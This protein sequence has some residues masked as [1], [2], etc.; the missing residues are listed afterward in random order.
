M[1]VVHTHE[2]IHNNN[3]KQEQGFSTLHTSKAGGRCEESRLDWMFLHEVQNIL[4]CVL[5]WEL[6]MCVRAA[7]GETE[8]QPSKIQMMS[9][10]AFMY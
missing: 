10:V 2:C 6:S 9:R 5:V 4:D 1:F 7:D 8:G 3:T